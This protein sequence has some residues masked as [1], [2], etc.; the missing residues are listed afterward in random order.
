MK[1]TI[2]KTTLIIIIL[3]LF[4]YNGYS[5]ISIES[6]SRA[7]D[8]IN[9]TLA[10]INRKLEDPNLS[11]SDSRQLIRER[12]TYQD[13]LNSLQSAIIKEESNKSEINNN[14]QNNNEASSNSENNN[15]I[16]DSIIPEN[17]D[18]TPSAGGSGTLGSN[19]SSIIDGETQ[20]T[21]GSS[22]GT[23]EG[24]VNQI[25]SGVTELPEGLID[26]INAG[27]EGVP[28]EL[29]D[30]LNNLSQNPQNI[31]PQELQQKYQ[32]LKNQLKEAT[33]EQAETIMNDFINQNV[34]HPQTP[35]TEAGSS[36]GSS[37]DGNTN[38]DGNPGRADDEKG[39]PGGTPGAGTDN[40][41]PTGKPGGTPGYGPGG[42]PDKGN[43]GISLTEDV[44]DSVV[45][46]VT[47]ENLNSTNSRKFLSEGAGSD[48]FSRDFGLTTGGDIYGSWKP[49][50]EIADMSA[51]QVMGVVDCADDNVAIEFLNSTEKIIGQFQGVLAGVDK[52]G[53]AIQKF[54][55]MA[56]ELTNILTETAG[57]VPIG[58]D[59][60]EPIGE[61]GGVLLDVT[62][63]GAGEMISGASNTADDALGNVQEGAQELEES[64][65]VRCAKRIVQLSNLQRE[66]LK[67]A[68]I[69]PEMNLYTP[70][71]PDMYIPTPE[72]PKRSKPTPPPEQKQ[73]SPNPCLGTPL[74]RVFTSVDKDYSENL[75]NIN[76]ASVNSIILNL[77]GA[78]SRDNSFELPIKE[79]IFC[80]GDMNQNNLTSCFEQ[81]YY[82]EDI[83]GN[84]TFQERQQLNNYGAGAL[85]GW[86]E[87]QLYDICSQPHCPAFDE[88]APCPTAEPIMSTYDPSSG[89]FVDTNM[90]DGTKFV[91]VGMADELN[92]QI[93]FYGDPKNPIYQEMLADGT[94]TPE[95]FASL[96]SQLQDMDKQRS[97]FMQCQ[98]GWD[99]SS[100]RMDCF[101]LVNFDPKTDVPEFECAEGTY[102]SGSSAATYKYFDSKTGEEI[103]N[104]DKIELFEAQNSGN[105]LNSVPNNPYLIA[106]IAVDNSTADIIKCQ[107]GW[108][109]TEC[110]DCPNQPICYRTERGENV[111]GTEETPA[112]VEDFRK[113]LGTLSVLS[114]DEDD[115]GG[116]AFASMRPTRP[117]PN[118]DNVIKDIQKSCNNRLYK[119]G[120]DYTTTIDLLDSNFKKDQWDFLFL[121]DSGPNERFFGGGDMNYISIFQGRFNDLFK[122]VHLQT[123][124][125]NDLVI[126]VN[127]NRAF[128]VYNE[129]G[130]GKGDVNIPEISKGDKLTIFFRDKGGKAFLNIGFNS[131]TIVTETQTYG[132]NASKV[133]EYAPEIIGYD[134][135]GCPEYAPCVPE[136]DK[137]QP[138]DL[139]TNYQECSFDADGCE[140]CTCTPIDKGDGEK[141]FDNT[142]VEDNSFDNPT[143][144]ESDTAVDE[145]TL[146]A[147]CE[148]Q[149]K[150]L[151]LLSV[152]SSTTNLSQRDA[153]RINNLVEKEI[154]K[155]C[156]YNDLINME[157]RGRQAM[158]TRGVSGFA[159][160]FPYVPGVSVIGEAFAVINNVYA[161]DGLPWGGDKHATEYIKMMSVDCD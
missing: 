91:D 32:N 40:P 111:I 46:P 20:G 17:K 112:T 155:A 58:G 143:F 72:L 74:D 113:S 54:G 69:D 2:F 146:S 71:K 130:D 129:G 127:N 68:K 53:G 102:L 128:S 120:R 151:D 150:V 31:N 11:Y 96:D 45:N 5:Q 73:S 38:N 132:E 82:S 86:I 37:N 7:V 154:P 159:S 3:F 84:K 59:L 116:E 145:D 36:G 136:C 80:G 87:A 98:S 97:G 126:Y 55:G 6:Y 109:E 95:L 105:I 12:D 121:D 30:F 21:L 42:N 147:M 152:T 48:I 139:S 62:S 75:D 160:P 131:G 90:P 157:V 115:C 83:S 61:G 108:S 101:E 117:N 56:A 89:R 15:T 124:F 141:L 57:I 10:D 29:S 14:N 106:Q 50:E 28:Q 135:D 137:P 133:T 104:K 35:D 76:Y 49:D 24:A 23:A 161:V 153:D 81:G 44:P 78:T 43:T 140:Q 34:P 93:D 9:S 18:N 156:D 47:K 70:R 103:T 22:I 94:L 26:T 19:I 107:T 60:V 118:P 123:R 51:I 125:D 66:I 144:D 85:Y 39:K 13:M 148:C 88:P 149:E 158:A 142:I 52:L 1:K 8:S 110:K 114:Y 138:C 65:L 63:G 134:E 100:C 16:K 33:P 64:L 99:T 77:K 92:R 27:G 122:D 119:G 41:P 79:K 67:L 25:K 4:T